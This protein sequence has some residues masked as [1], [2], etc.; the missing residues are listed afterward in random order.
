MDSYYTGSIM[1]YNNELISF[2]N[3]LSI[4]QQN[5]KHSDSSRILDELSSMNLRMNNPQ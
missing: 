4:K 2:L 1:A 3:T 5:L